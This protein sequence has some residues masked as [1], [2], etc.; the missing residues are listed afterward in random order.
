MLTLP[1]R[2]RKPKSA[3]N[4]HQSR[5]HPAALSFLRSRIIS[6]EVA[7]RKA[8]TFGSL[9]Q[10][11]LGPG[12][13]ESRKVGQLARWVS[14]DQRSSIRRTLDRDG[15]R[16]S[17]STTIRPKTDLPILRLNRRRPFCDAV[18]TSL[19]LQIADLQSTKYGNTCSRGAH[20]WACKGLRELN[21]PS[22]RAAASSVAP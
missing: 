22:A 20:R 5:K 4:S 19:I 6:G 9:T 14:N 15:D 2:P 3:R 13:R 10:I 1:T 18:S 12:V 21:N 7:L 17:I 16:A 8:C 11:S